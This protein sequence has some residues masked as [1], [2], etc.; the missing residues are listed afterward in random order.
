MSSNNMSKDP[1][2]NN[3]DYTLKG[4]NR[5][6]KRKTLRKRIK[7]KTCKRMFRRSIKSRNKR[8]RTYARTNR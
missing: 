1:F 8:K 3:L 2:F 6:R 7:C 5:K 4:G